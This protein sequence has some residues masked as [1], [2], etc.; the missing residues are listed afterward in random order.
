[1]Q[2]SIDLLMAYANKIAFGL[3]IKEQAV[4]ERTI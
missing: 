2:S 3:A 4:N 1:M